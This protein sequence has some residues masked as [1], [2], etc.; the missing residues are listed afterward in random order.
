MT[1]IPATAGCWFWALKPSGQKVT[2][3][4]RIQCF[5]YHGLMAR[6]DV[7]RHKTIGA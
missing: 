6:F 5:C 7:V 4:T 2:K 3:W 1:R